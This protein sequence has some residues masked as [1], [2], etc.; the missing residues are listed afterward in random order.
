MNRITQSILR[1]L[2]I[3]MC[4]MLLLTACETMPT[5]MNGGDNGGDM[6]SNGGDNNSN[7]GDNNSNGDNNTNETFDRLFV[8]NNSARI[9]SF[10]NPATADGDVAPA[11]ELPVGASTDIFQPR[12]LVVTNDF[13]LLVTRQNGGIT[14]HD[15]AIDTTG[16]VP[17]D[18]ITESDP[19][20]DAPIA[21]AYDADSDTLYVG[22]VNSESGI[23]V[24]NNASA[25]TFDGTKGPDRI[26]NPSDRAP[27]NTTEMTI[28]AL[29]LD[30]DGRLYVS[31]TSGTNVNFSRILVFNNPDTA[32]GDTPAD[33]KLESKEW[34]NIEDLCVDLDDNLYIVDDTDA[35]FKIKSASTVDGTD[36]TPDVTLTIVG[37]SVALNGIV[38]D[39]HGRAYVS[40]RGNHEIHSLAGIAALSSGNATPST[41]ITGN[42]TRLSAPRQLWLV[43]EIEV[44]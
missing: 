39:R 34:G 44:E 7:G 38:V 27:T 17:A 13:T 15:L 32:S 28:D 19:E 11:T 14:S 5:D 35:I 9:I 1:A 31:D 42:A 36:L 10:T 22:G 43:E 26:F 18:R 37:Q 41:T 4:L 25:A 16:N 21:L 33:R 2:S 6:N 23:L 30:K 8:V 40:D 29:W 12:S 20:L 3:S 24:Y